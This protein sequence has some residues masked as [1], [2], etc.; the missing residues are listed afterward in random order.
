MKVYHVGVAYVCRSTLWEWDM[1]V[2][3]P[4]G[5]WDMCVGLPCGSGTCV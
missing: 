4:C 1:C 3:L 2:D 5:E